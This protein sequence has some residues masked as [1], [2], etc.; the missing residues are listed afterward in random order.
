MY[1]GFRVS[2]INA[3]GGRAQDHYNIMMSVAYKLMHN[4]ILTKL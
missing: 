4:A 3:S 1:N 2:V